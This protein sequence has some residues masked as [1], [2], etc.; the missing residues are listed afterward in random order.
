MQLVQLTDWDGAGMAVAHGHKAFHEAVG[1]RML[2]PLSGH[3]LLEAG[4]DRQCGD[5]HGLRYR[6]EEVL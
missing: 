2:E 3:A 1:V 5:Q 6:L 4:F